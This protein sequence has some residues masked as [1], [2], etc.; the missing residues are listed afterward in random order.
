MLSYLSSCEEQEV[1]MNST[2]TVTKKVLKVLT[3]S[4]DN[5]E[6][7]KLYNGLVLLL[8]GDQL[9]AQLQNLNRSAESTLL[10]FFIF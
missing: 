5:L 7:F 3:I 1:K 4:I 10:C 2:T 9:K 6:F 8:P